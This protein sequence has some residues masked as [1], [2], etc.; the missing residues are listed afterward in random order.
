MVDGAIYNTSP[1]LSLKTAALGAFHFPMN[2]YVYYVPTNPL[3]IRDKFCSVDKIYCF[4]TSIKTTLI[5]INILSKLWALNLI[6]AFI[7]DCVMQWNEELK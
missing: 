3:C 6:Q 1:I 4:Q 5:T 2:N 7:F